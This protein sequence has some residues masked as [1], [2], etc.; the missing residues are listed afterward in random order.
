MRV[1][2]TCF[3]TTLTGIHVYN[4]YMT[5]N[6]SIVVNLRRFRVLCYT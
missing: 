3:S 4:T 1:M 5:L 2:L 6:T